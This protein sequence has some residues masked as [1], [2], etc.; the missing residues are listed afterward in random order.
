MEH[1]ILMLLMMIMMITTT[2]DDDDDSWYTYNEA[3][4]IFSDL[5]KV[6]QIRLK[7]SSR[8]SQYVN[9]QIYVYC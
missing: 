3:K 6:M 9:K 5:N 8:L 7:S 2:N 1:L 4:K